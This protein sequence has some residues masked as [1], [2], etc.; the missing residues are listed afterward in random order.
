MMLN[1]A[2]AREK[3]DDELLHG[4]QVLQALPDGV[5][6]CNRAGI[7]RFVNPAAARLL[8][9]DADAYVGRP[10]ATLP[11]GITLPGEVGH[12][13]YEQFIKI[14]YEDRHCRIVPIWSEARKKAHIGFLITIKLVLLEAISVEKLRE[15]IG[16]ELR[17]PLT[18]IT[19]ASEILLRGLAGE[20]SESQRDITQIIGQGSKRLAGIVNNL[21]AVMR[22]EAGHMR[23][24]IE[25]VDLSQVIKDSRESKQKLIDD[26]NITC[27]V[28]G[29]PDT[30][31][32][33]VDRD[34]LYEIVSQ[35]LDNACRYTPAGGNIRVS[36]RIESDRVR[37]DI[38]DTGIGIS[39]SV[40]QRIFTQSVNDYR[41]PLRDKIDHYSGVG[42]GLIIARRLVDLH[43]GKLWFE[44]TVGQGSTFSFSLPI[45]GPAYSYVQND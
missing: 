20:L 23:L 40:Q 42:L 31:N 18:S 4:S 37:C 38:Q 44:S 33:R 39:Q 2:P 32:V 6:L 30:L 17:G 10:L 13:T 26:R 22:F 14:E 25:E 15:I 35:L 27:D 29:L 5:V 36:V 41:N 28:N 43:G 1:A 24:F 11:G 16:Y 3:P 8:Q 34:K 7:V 9:I 21:F 19:A 45:S 12:R